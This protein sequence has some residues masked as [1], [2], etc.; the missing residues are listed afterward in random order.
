MKTVYSVGQVNRYVKNMFIQ[1]YVLRKVYVKGEVSNCKYHTSGHIYFSLKD[2]T[3]VLSCVM[4]A[5]QRRGLAFRMKDGDRVVVGGAVDVYERDGRYQMY[6]KEITLEGAGALYERFL[7]LK[8]ELEE[9]GMFA[10]EYKQPIPRFIRRLGV[11]T[12]PTARLCRISGIFPC[13]EIRTCRSSF[14]RHWYRAMEQQ[15]AS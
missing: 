10:P 1:D 13:G 7:A 5:G 14:I 11:V 8:A 9:M 12:A 3:G 2:E 15:T 4:F 6:A